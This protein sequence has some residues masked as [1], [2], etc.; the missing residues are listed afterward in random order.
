MRRRRHAVFSIPLLVALFMAPV[1]SRPGKAPAI[2][3]SKASKL[4]TEGDELLKNGEHERAIKKFQRAHRLEEG[5]SFDAL[6]RI[7]H[8]P[9]HG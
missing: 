1:A 3:S 4:M 7:S 2:D 5:G 9:I 8:L 6:M